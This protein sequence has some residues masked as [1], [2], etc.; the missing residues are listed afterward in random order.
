MIMAACFNGAER[1]RAQWTRLL[2]AADERLV[3]ENINRPEGSTMSIIEVVWEKELVLR[4]KLSM[5]HIE[6]S[7]RY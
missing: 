6:D 4:L 3:I 5:S 1:T 7:M 2:H